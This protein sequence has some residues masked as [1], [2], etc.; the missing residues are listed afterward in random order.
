MALEAVGR[1]RRVL[2]MRSISIRR[3]RSSRISARRSSSPAMRWRSS[4]QWIAE[5]RN[6]PRLASCNVIVR[7]H[8]RSVRQWSEVDLARHGRV[9]SV[10]V[11]GAQCRSVSLR[12][13]LSQ[14]RRR[15]AQHQRADRGRH[16]RQTGAD[17]ARAGFREGPA[18]ARSTSATCSGRKVGSSSWLTISTSTRTHLA[19]AVGGRLRRRRDP[20]RGR[21]V[22]PARR[23]G[24]DRPRRFWPMRLPTWRLRSRRRFGGGCTRQRGQDDE[25]RPADAHSVSRHAHDDA[26]AFRER[27]AGIGGP[28]SY[29]PHRVASQ[30]G[31]S[32]AGGVGRASSHCVHHEPGP[33]RR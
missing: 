28:G 25:R 9:R 32:A 7:P 18:A 33:A 30:S 3:R 8:P 27:A 10:V 23:V 4:K 11:A 20:Q 29:R 31:D 22:H 17:A 15:W 16:S 26:A 19:R 21:A 6:D 24:I 12:R 1:S 13:A 14:R 5:I 2:P